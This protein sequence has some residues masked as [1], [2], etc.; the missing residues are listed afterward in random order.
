MTGRSNDYS[1][2][3]A[4]N[5]LPCAKKS[6]GDVPY[7]TATGAGGPVRQQL[8]LLH[9]D[10]L[11]FSLSIK[12]PEHTKCFADMGPA[13]IVTVGDSIAQPEGL[14]VQIRHRNHRAALEAL[15]E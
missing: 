11:P 14:P 8:N 5:R 6:R 2:V 3:L 12:V 15:A 13:N 7:S 10:N 4:D 9:Y 1:R